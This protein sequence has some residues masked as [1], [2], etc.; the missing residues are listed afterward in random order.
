MKTVKKEL[1]NIYEGDIVTV[2]SLL[3]EIQ[4]EQDEQVISDIKE[5]FNSAID[6]TVVITSR[7]ISYNGVIVF[8]VNDFPTKLFLLPEAVLDVCVNEIAVQ[9]IIAVLNNNY[10]PNSTVAATLTVQD[11]MKSK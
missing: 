1:Y 3:R 8:T 9:D 7:D 10:D 2:S 6:E 5:Y 4:E 11:I